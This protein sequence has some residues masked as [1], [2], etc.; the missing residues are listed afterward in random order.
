MLSGNNFFF[1]RNVALA[2]IY[3]EIILIVL[4]IHIDAKF[5]S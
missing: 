4:N 2:Q 5:H 3:E 1:K